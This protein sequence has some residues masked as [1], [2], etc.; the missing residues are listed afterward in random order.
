MDRILMVDDSAFMR[1]LISDILNKIPNVSEVRI[2]RNGQNCLDILDADNG[3]DLILMDIEMPVMD[4]LSALRQIKKDYSIPVVMLSAVNDQAVTIKALEYGAADFIEKP[5]N[6]MEI[7]DEWVRELYAKIKNICGRSSKPQ[8][9]ARHITAANSNNPN[10]AHKKR[11]AK[12][13]AVVIGS[14]TGGPKALLEI[15]KGVSHTNVPVFIVQHMPAGFTRTFSERLNE[16]SGATVVE[17][18]DNMLIKNQIYLCPGNYHMTIQ[19]DRL[20]LDQRPKMHGTRPAV[21]YL[22]ETAAAHYGADL[23][24]FILTG[25]GH[26]GTAGLQTIMD[27]GGYAIAEDQESCTVFGM[28]RSAIEAHVVDEVV[29]LHEIG[30]ILQTIV[31]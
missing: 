1:K 31:G 19:G 24:A 27:E 16:E 28:P 13:Q 2:A 22:F 7:Q 14:S 5:V 23:T 3:F 29:S 10:R 21:D 4:G 12:P 26:D 25:M 9:S 18:S 30:K 8:V 11:N 6:L 17:A 20:K 15:I